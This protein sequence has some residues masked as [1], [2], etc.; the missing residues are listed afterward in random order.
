L[1]PK[2]PKFEAEERV[3]EGVLGEGATSPL[4]TIYE[5]WRSAVS[6]PAGSGWGRALEKF[7]FWMHYEP[8]LEKPRFF[9]RSF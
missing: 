9:V 5:V 8:G 1:R 2:W 4:T 7:A 3:Q 6:S